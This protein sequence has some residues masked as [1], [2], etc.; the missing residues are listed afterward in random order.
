M[1]TILTPEELC[2]VLKIS[3]RTLYRM[4]TKGQMTF[5]FKL[6]GSWRFFEKDIIKWLN[7]SKVTR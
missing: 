6:N 4:I 2:K 1:D 3:Q 7:Q 5:A